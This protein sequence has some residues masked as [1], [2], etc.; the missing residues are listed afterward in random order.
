MFTYHNIN[1]TIKPS[2]YNYS[3]WL[4]V[5]LFIETF[6][7]IILIK[8]N[9]EERQFSYAWQ[10]SCLRNEY[11]SGLL[12]CYLVS[13]ITSVIYFINQYLFRIQT[14]CLTLMVSSTHLY[15]CSS[16]NNPVTTNHRTTCTCTSKLSVLYNLFYAFEFF[17][18]SIIKMYVIL[19]QIKSGTA[20]RA[21]QWS[22][23]KH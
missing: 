9:P 14:I 15:C 18:H 22:H 13:L 21:A 10:L 8:K 20:Q 16:I 1:M 7:K 6:K 5:H 11:P 19:H 3:Q 17:Q 4:F 23:V 12:H 2:K